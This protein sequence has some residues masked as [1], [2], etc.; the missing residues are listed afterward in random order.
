MRIQNFSSDVRAWLDDL[1]IPDPVDRRMAALLQFI[2]LGFMGIIL[3]ALILNPILGADLSPQD[4]QT[5][6]VANSI[7][8]VV[9]ALPMVLLRRGYFHA[10]VLIVIGILFVFSTLSV[11]LAMSLR[12]TN[13][14][15]FPLTFSLILAGLLVGKRALLV[16]FVLSI[17]VLMLGASLERSSDPELRL[18]NI[19]IAVNFVLF[20]GLMCLFL[21]RF[22]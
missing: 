20:N 13:G 21:H 7:G 1:P 6:M 11:V 3:L 14:T 17:G 10:S 5:T 2:L 16:T 4:L 19:A 9:L 18:N 22:G 8:V 15:L 12:E